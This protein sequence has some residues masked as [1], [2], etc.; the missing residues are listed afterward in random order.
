MCGV[1]PPPS[2]PRK[3]RAVRGKLYIAEADL[4]GGMSVAGGRRVHLGRSVDI[5]DGLSYE[6]RC[7]DEAGEADG[8][9][10]DAAFARGDPQQ[11]ISDHGGEDLQADRV[12]GAAEELAKLQMLLDP[13]EQQLDLPAGLVKRGGPDRRTGPIRLDQGQVWA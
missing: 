6:Q 10:D 8:R 1:K 9:H 11:Q 12:L 3:R 2:S 13:A 5:D 4:V 7:C